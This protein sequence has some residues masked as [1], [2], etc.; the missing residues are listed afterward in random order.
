MTVRTSW[1]P[2]A[3]PPIPPGHR[4]SIA[5]RHDAFTVARFDRVRVLSTELKRLVAAG[6]PVAVRFG[7]FPPLAGARL[8]SVLAWL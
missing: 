4:R 1:D 6:A 8:A 7:A 5:A 3:A 2:D